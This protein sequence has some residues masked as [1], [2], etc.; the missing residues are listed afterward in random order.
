MTDQDFRDIIAKGWFEKA[1]D[2]YGTAEVLL[3]ERRLIACVNRMYYAA[4]YA[5]SAILAKRGNEYGRHTAVRASL[6]RDFVK[7]GIVPKECGRTFDEL[8]DDRQ[9]GDY[10]PKTSFS[11]EEVFRLLKA[12]RS[13]L[14]CFKSLL[15]A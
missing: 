6:H 11:E 2:A 1:E 3:R 13:F 14:D 15:D 8:F 10:T 7:A 4:F 12:T 9:K 5:V